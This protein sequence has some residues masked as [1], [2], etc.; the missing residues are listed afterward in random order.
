MNDEHLYT[1]IY[2]SVTGDPFRVKSEMVSHYLNKVKKESKV[3]DSK[4]VFTGK[5]IPAFV[6]TK[7]E[8]IGSP[9]SG[10]IQQVA[11]VGQ[12]KAGKRRR[13]RRGRKK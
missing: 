12:S 13:G 6:K 9:S 8:I 5:W 2:D 1:E 10:E 11:P 3:V 7:K 4:L